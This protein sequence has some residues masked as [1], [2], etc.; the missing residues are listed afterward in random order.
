MKSMIDYLIYYKEKIPEKDAIIDR[1]EKYTYA[2]LV[3]K[4]EVV[5]SYL[6]N[7]GIR[8]GERVLLRAVGRTQ[9]VICFLA[10]QYLGAISIPV[11]RMTNQENLLNIIKKAKA[12]FFLSSTKKEYPGIITICYEDLFAKAHELN[13]CNL[14]D[15]QKVEDT[16]TCEIIFTT[17]TTG[18][19]KGAMHNRKAII[20]N[21]W[22]TINGIGMKESDIVLLSLPLSHSFG[23]RVMRAGL[24]LGATL[25]LQEGSSFAKETVRN[26]NKYSCTGL[27]CVASSM[28]IMIEELGESVAA[29]SFGSLRY[30]EFS[31]GAVEKNFREFLVKLLPNTEIHNTWGCTEAGGCFFINISNETN[32]MGSMGKAIDTVQVKI[33]DYEGMEIVR[34]GANA[35]GKLAIKGEMLMSG[36][37]EEENLEE[38]TLKNGW[39]IT[40]D[41]VWKDK[42]GYFYIL[43]RCDDI[44]NTGGEKVAPQEIENI[45]ME[46]QGIDECACLG[47]EDIHGH[48]GEIPILFVH[49]GKKCV[50]SWKKELTDLLNL[51]LAK[52]KVPKEIIEI[53][54]L[55]RNTMGKIDRKELKKIWN[56]SLKKPPL[57]VVFEN[58]LSRRSIRHFSDQDVERH[59]VEQLV[60]CGKNAPSGKNLHTRRFTVLYTRKQ[61]E[62]FKDVVYRTAKANDIA[63]NGFY[64]P[65]VLILVSDDRRNKDGIQDVSCAVENIMLAATSLGMGSVWINVLMDLC[66]DEDIRKCLQEYG[67][68][69]KHWVWATIVLG[70][71]A[72]KETFIE[73]KDDIVTFF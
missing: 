49:K 55:P 58:I 53:E 4:V 57:N 60:E 64:N 30:I 43:G 38:N 25:I 2:Q 14:L 66:D 19:P 51:R 65:K 1:N 31:A 37:C 45:A 71:P 52:H 44:I 21:T 48:M 33:L 16:D 56:K 15:I 54:Y 24:V 27:A 50:A 6:Y 39:L 32:K 68:P 67:I 62:K 35:S 72:N 59:I 70:W 36:Y 8:R 7:N 34:T 22:N 9:Y 3:E 28:K 11:D 40:N 41:I 69:E 23:L 63:V 61:V 13:N 5:A 29:E 42:D 17:G 47:V 18:T 26:I 12:K 46:I 20:T 73:R 10:L